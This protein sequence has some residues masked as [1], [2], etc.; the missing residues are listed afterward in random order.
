MKMLKDLIRVYNSIETL[1]SAVRQIGEFRV[2]SLVHPCNLFLTLNLFEF[3][4][5]P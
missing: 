5:L 4:E 3:L 2:A 1:S